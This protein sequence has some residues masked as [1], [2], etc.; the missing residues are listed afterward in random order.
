MGVQFIEKDSRLK[1]TVLLFERR[2]RKPL[3]QKGYSSERHQD[4]DCALSERIISKY[5]N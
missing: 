3:N 1:S 4:H 2:F 5:M